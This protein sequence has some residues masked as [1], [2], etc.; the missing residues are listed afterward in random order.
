MSECARI[1]TEATGWESDYIPPW[2]NRPAP[3]RPKLE[4]LLEAN[5]KRSKKD[6]HR[7]TRIFD[8][9]R[10]EGFEGGYDSI[11]RFAQNWRR[12]RKG[13][14][15]QAFVPLLFAP[16]E[17]Y[18]FDWSHEYVVMDG[19]TTLVKAAHFRLCHSRMRFVI[20]YPANTVLR[21]ASVNGGVKSGHWAAQNEATLELGATRTTM[22]RPSAC[23]I[24]HTSCRH[25]I[26]ILR[27]KYR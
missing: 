25:S 21:F 18:Q 3:P 4:A 20:C 19:V 23:V 22:R 27:F 7:L 15:A 1:C 11:R 6:R 8:D 13:G 10:C 17:A 24:D 2:A 26:S 9:L 16:G 12:A 5:E 14:V